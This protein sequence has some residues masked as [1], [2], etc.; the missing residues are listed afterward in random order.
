MG[1]RDDDGLGDDAG[2]DDDGDK[3][4]YYDRKR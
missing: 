4:F 2:D 3:V 1:L